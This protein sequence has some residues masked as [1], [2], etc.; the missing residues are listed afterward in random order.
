MSNLAK[1]VLKNCVGCGACVE[2]CP[3]NAIPDTVIGCISSLARI[4]KQKCDGCGDCLRV[5]SHSAITL[6]NGIASIDKI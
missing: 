1:L 6:I 2:I 3:N 5:C 4:N